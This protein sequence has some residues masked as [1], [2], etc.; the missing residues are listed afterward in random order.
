MVLFLP[1][2]IG[3]SSQNH[4]IVLLFSSLILNPTANIGF[5]TV[6]STR[7]IGCSMTMAF[8]QLKERGRLILNP[9]I[10]LFGGNQ[11][12]ETKVIKESL[13]KLRETVNEIGVKL[14]AN[15]DSHDGRN[16]SYNQSGTL[17]EEAK[18]LATA[19]I[20]TRNGSS[21]SDKNVANMTFDVAN[22]KLVTSI[23]IE[24]L[25][26]LS[27]MTGLK[28]SNSTF[29]KSASFTNLMYDSCMEIFRSAKSGCEEVITNLNK[30]CQEDFG[31]ALSQ[32]SCTPVFSST[33]RVCPMLVHELIDEKSIC[34]QM[35][36]VSIW[37]IDHLIDWNDRRGNYSKEVVPP[38][39]RTGSNMDHHPPGTLPLSSLNIERNKT[40]INELFAELNKRIDKIT[41]KFDGEAA[42]ATARSI[43]KRVELSI[44]LNDKT[45]EVFKKT[46]SMVEYVKDKYR[47]RKYLSDAIYL[48]YDLYSTFIFINIMI[49]ARN[50]LRSYLRDIKFDN[51]Y[52]TSV[53]VRMDEGLARKERVLPLSD[54]EEMKYLTTFTCRRRTRDELKHQRTS[55]RSGILFLA[56]SCSLMYLDNIFYYIL[57]S[58]HRHSLIKYHDLGHHSV[59]IAVRGQGSLARIIRQLTHRLNS[60]YEMDR[61]TTT[62]ACLPEPR[63]T[64]VT[65]YIDFFGLI[66][67][68]LIMD[69][70]IIY[71]MRF[72]RLTC[73]Y[74]FPEKE[75]ER[76]VYLRKK[77]L[78][79]RKM[80]LSNLGSKRSI[81]QGASDPRA[82][83]KVTKE[84]KSDET[85]W[86]VGNDNEVAYT[87]RDVAD[88]LVVCAKKSYICFT[89]CHL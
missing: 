28:L 86:L 49:E 56:L 25:G 10:E 45:T 73:A 80:H 74:F 5:N 50:Y 9:V 76:L 40:T 6:E 29:N 85:S 43:P 16:S 34:R 4:I 70:L 67:A 32:I 47:L 62:M 12:E 65:F 46:Q 3:T 79:D 82:S 53:F 55:C 26:R 78:L 37:E 41:L 83:E 7:V 24:K 59:N 63:K 1:S 71:A 72:R 22:L 44:G 84:K 54:D 42:N 61:T 88:Y 58:I 48:V 51:F 18:S 17:L 33:T 57:D 69:Q 60:A 87:I 52:I 30:D 36:N 31:Y 75:R 64:R 89:Q 81:D 27:N 14:S 38:N 11:E 39:P 23:D 19:I 21:A 66:M 20:G 68:Y 8:D 77:I 15:H 13:S 35:R 2:L